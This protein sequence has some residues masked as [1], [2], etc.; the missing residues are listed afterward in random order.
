M[1]FEDLDAYVPTQTVGAIQLEDG[2][3]ERVAAFLRS[4]GYA[5]KTPRS[6]TLQLPWAGSRRSVASFGDWVVLWH[7]PFS[8]GEWRLR[9]VDP[10]DFEREFRLK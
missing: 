9:L 6:D 5:A 3:V 7:D 2:N 4:V 8:A 1:T 10:S